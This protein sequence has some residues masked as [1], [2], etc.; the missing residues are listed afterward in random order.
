MKYN[1]NYNLGANSKDQRKGMHLRESGYELKIK[2]IVEIVL[3]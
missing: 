2:K 1:F 3:R